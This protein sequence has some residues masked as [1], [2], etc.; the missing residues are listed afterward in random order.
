[1]EKK[2]P[3]VLFCPYCGTENIKEMK[4]Y[5]MQC[6]DC[7]IRFWVNYSRHLRKARKIID[8]K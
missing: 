7:R 5:L 6:N 1:M 3:E 8:E 2:P 4:W